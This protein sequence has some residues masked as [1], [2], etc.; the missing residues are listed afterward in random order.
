M[1]D[2]PDLKKTVLIAEDDYAGYLYL[3]SLLSGKG[4]KIIRTTDGEATV[5]TALENP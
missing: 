5:K 4:F 2:A 1:S 3:E